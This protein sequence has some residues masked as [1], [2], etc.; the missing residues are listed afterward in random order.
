MFSPIGPKNFST[1][2]TPELVQ[3]LAHMACLHL[4]P[5][6]AQSLCVD[7]AKVV[8]WFS[9]LQSVDTA[10]MEPLIHPICIQNGLLRADSPGAA[11]PVQQVVGNSPMHDSSYIHIPD[12]KNTK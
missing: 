8:D 5:E 9:A 11:L 3:E 1:A 12:T 10:G 7:L 4:S 2:I 6:E